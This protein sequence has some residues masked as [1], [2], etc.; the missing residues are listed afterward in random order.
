M[1]PSTTPNK[2]SVPKVVPMKESFWEKFKRSQ[3]VSKQ[4][5]SKVKKPLRDRARSIRKDSY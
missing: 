5:M 4:R 3:R 2:V 1:D